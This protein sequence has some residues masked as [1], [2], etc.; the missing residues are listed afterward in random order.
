MKV[1]VYNQEGKEVEELELPEGV[2]GVKLNKDLVHQT[3]VTQMANARESIAH[4]KDRS[5]VRGGGKKPWRQ[6]G[7][8]RA[9][10]GSIRSPIWRG[11]GVTF[12][13]TNKRVF[14]KKINKKMRQKALLMVLSSKA[15]DNELIILDNLK[16]NS[17]KTKE[18]AAIV[19]NLENIKKDIKRSVLI[20]LAKKDENVIKAVKN[21]PKMGSI[22]INSL[23]VV[24]VLKYKYLVITKAGINGLKTGKEKTTV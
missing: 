9:R 17:P 6:K 24:D 7:T 2:F 19:K 4:T 8:G 21:I 11:G 20:A 14:S 18:V 23:N 13:P 22:G 5:E 12:G 16:I 1:K 10:H 3:V 15:K